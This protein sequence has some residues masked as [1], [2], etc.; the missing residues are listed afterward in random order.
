MSI[1]LLL[2]EEK[3]NSLQSVALSEQFGRTQRV[4]DSDW[5]IAAQTDVMLD[6]KQLMSNTCDGAESYIPLALMGY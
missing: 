3:C 2:Y 1:Y 6:M 4:L 5:D